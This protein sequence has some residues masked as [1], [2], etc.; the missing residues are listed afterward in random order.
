MNYK[1]KLYNVLCRHNL[2]NVESIN[3]NVVR[4]CNSKCLTCIYWKSDFQKL[5]IGKFMTAINI[6]GDY[7]CKNKT[8]NAN[9][10]GEGEP[11]LNHSI[12]Q[13]IKVCKEK[14]YRVNLITNASML[15]G[16]NISRLVE[17]G[18]DNINFS[19][20]SSVP[21]INDFQ[22]GIKGHFS[23]VISS[24]NSLEKYK[25]SHKFHIGI[26]ATVTSYNIEKIPELVRFADNNNSISSIRFQ[27]VMPVFGH[28]EMIPVEKDR[29]STHLWPKD[30]RIIRRVY[31]NLIEQL[32]FS[33]KI[34]NTKKSLVAQM[35]YFLNPDI[36]FESGECDIYK[37]LTINP[38][39][40]IFSC[41]MIH[42]RGGLFENEVL[43]S[44]NT[45]ST[46]T[47]I[48]NK[49]H[50]IMQKIKSCKA[51]NC[52]LLINCKLEYSSRD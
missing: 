27:A 49:K 36:F 33:R 52:H 6:I 14:G 2:R 20:E 4:G 12:Y 22:R 31:M 32:G 50:E 18:I 41:P 37:S 48:D 24:I 11:L 3:I 9:F 25:S 16:K 28:A 7:T 17:S 34:Q 23:R 26:L 8:I 35:N 44:P 39:G 38:E 19:L 13:M 42:L 21:K 43:Y 1:S 10:G 15:V 40:K 45:K 46:L 29:N 30:K 5:D 51:K 47:E